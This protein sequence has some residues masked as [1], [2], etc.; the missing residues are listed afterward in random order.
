MMVHLIV[1]M[2]SVS[3]YE[4]AQAADFAPIEVGNRWVYVR[5]VF[6]GQHVGSYSIDT[7]A[8]EVVEESFE[9]HDQRGYF[10]E[11]IGSP[12]WPGSKAIFRVDEL[13]RIVRRV[14]GGIP[15]PDTSAFLRDSAGFSEEFRDQV[16]AWP[17]GQN[18]IVYID[19][20]MDASSEDPFTRAY[21]DWY[22][23]YVDSILDYHTVQMAGESDEWPWSEFERPVPQRFR[24]GARRSVVTLQS[25]VI[26]MEGYTTYLFED[27][28]GLVAEYSSSVISIGRATTTLLW[29]RLDGVEYDN[30]ATIAGIQSWAEVK[31]WF[32]PGERRDRRSSERPR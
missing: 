31:E 5:E 18:E 29:A 27:G 4:S 22:G 16:S 19:F 24:R 7:C 17:S 25:N 9:V 15:V 6:D 10:A 26:A 1:L 32:R 20:S 28:F 14:D 3:L 2:C 30:R 23:R 11:G 12:C 21:L 13:G 8:V